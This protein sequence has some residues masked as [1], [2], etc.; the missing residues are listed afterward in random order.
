[1]SSISCPIPHALPSAPH[2]NTTGVIYFALPNLLEHFGSPRFLGSPLVPLP[3]SRDPGRATV[4]TATETP[5]C[6]PRLSD[7]EG[8][9]DTSISRLI[10][11][12]LIPA[13]HA[14]TFGF[15]YNGKTRFRLGGSPYRMGFEPIRLLQ[16]ISRAAL[17]PPIPTL[18]ASPGAT[19]LRPL[20]PVPRQFPPPYACPK[21]RLAMSITDGR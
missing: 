17:S 21:K 6:R 20:T 3:C 11:K 1:M 5:W 18:Q 10:H 14:S 2:S 16:R 4:S 19:D 12:A 7:D 8:P 15:P 13:V 9:N